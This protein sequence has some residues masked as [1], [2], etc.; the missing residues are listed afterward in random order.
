MFRQTF[1]QPIVSTGLWLPG[2]KSE[3]L[4]QISVFESFW[5]SRQ[6]KSREG[7]LAGSQPVLTSAHGPGMRLGRAWGTRRDLFAAL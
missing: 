7:R 3:N 4:P 1:C 6:M 5:A 2:M